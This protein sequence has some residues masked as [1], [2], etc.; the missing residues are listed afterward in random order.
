MTGNKGTIEKRLSNP[1]L[2]LVVGAGIT[3]LLVPYITNQ[4]QNHEKELELK[5]SLVTRISEAV[6]RALTAAQFTNARLPAVVDYYQSYHDWETAHSA[7]GSY[8][9]AYFPNT[10]LGEEWDEYANITTSLIRLSANNSMSEKEQLVGQIQEYFSSCSNNINW[11]ALL[12]VNDIRFRNEDF[13]YN[14]F[15]VKEQV[16][17]AKNNISQKVLEIPILTQNPFWQYSDD[18]RRSI[19]SSLQC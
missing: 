16:I 7:I 17:L 14:W 12:D 1:L 13:R 5:T 15:I 9:R 8:I 4:W 18:T 3:G 19:V 11:N 6:S 10:H 2:L